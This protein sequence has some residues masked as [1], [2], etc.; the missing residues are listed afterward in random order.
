MNQDFPCDYIPLESLNRILFT[1]GQLKILS[2]V[3]EY[4][5]SEWAGQPCDARKDFLEEL[6]HTFGM[7]DVLEK[8]K[9]SKLGEFYL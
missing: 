4:G 6:Y 9:K 5:L 7:E 3:N 2:L 1:E 8:I